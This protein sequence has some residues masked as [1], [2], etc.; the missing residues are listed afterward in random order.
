MCL[1]NGTRCLDLVGHT[2]SISNLVSLDSVLISSSYDAS[3]KI[4]NL[5]GKEKA[6]LKEHKRGILQMCLHGD[7]QILSGDRSGNVFVWNLM[8][9]KALWKLKRIHQGHITA[10]YWGQN[11]SNFFTGGQDGILRLW[12]PRQ[13]TNVFK[14]RIHGDATHHAAINQILKPSKDPLL[15]TNGADKTFKVAIFTTAGNKG[16]SRSSIFERIALNLYGKVVY[17]IS[18]TA[19]KFMALWRFLVV[20]MEALS[21]A[22]LK[23]RW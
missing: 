13:R 14:E 11:T 10:L 12:D 18:H 4:W 20:A 19:E 7:D 1:W 5:S 2:G 3:L 15:I 8:D 21:F 22:T 17:L 23:I 16:C 9:S 6:T